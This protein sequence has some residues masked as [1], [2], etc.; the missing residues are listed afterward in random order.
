MYVYFDCDLFTQKIE[1]DNSSQIYDSLHGSENKLLI[2]KDA[3]SKQ[4]MVKIIFFFKLLSFRV[5]S[6]KYL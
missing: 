5:L 6:V 4:I 1:V 3:L 2:A